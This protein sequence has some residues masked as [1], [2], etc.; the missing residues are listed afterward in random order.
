[1][2]SEKKP[3]LKFLSAWETCWLSPLQVFY[4]LFFIFF[5]SYICELVNIINI[6]PFMSIITQINIFITWV[7]K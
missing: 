4:F 6:S 7:K 5:K 1:M 3:M 2:V